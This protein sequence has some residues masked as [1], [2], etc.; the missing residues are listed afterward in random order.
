MSG[1]MHIIFD[2]SSRLEREE[3]YFKYKEREFKLLHNTEE[4]WYALM[5][6][7]D[8]PNSQ[9]NEVYKITVEYLS[10]LSWQNR[11]SITIESLLWGRDGVTLRK[12]GIRIHGIRQKSKEY[13]SINDSISVVPQV[14]SEIQ[15]TALA[16]FSEAYSNPSPYFK[17]LFYWHVIDTGERKMRRKFA[18]NWIDEAMKNRRI[19]TSR[20][21]LSILQKRPEELGEYFYLSCR[22]AVAHIFRPGARQLQIDNWDDRRRFHISANIM[23][24]FARFYIETELGLKKKMHLIKGNTDDFPF[25]ASEQELQGKTYELA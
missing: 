17:F 21:Y 8:D 10:A 15:Q 12:E 14:E 16:L 5:T 6:M 11:T 22:H 25:Y 24:K 9:R 18:N 7:L 1:W 20:G 23:E 4:G 3:Y 19:T 13:R 2:S